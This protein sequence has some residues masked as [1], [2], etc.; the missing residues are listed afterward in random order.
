MS[1]QLSENKPILP[2]F[3]LTF[4]LTLPGYILLY[5]TANGSILTPDMT[6]VFIPVITLAPVSAALIL[7]ARNEGRA[8]VKKLL[9]RTFDY[10]RITRKSWIATTLLFPLAIFLVALAVAKLL[11]FTTNPAQAPLILFPIVFIGLFGGAWGENIAWM[12]YAFDTMENR[13]NALKA[14]IILGL[15]LT[16]WHIPIYMYATDDPVFLPSMILFPLTLRILAVWIFNNTGKSVFAATVFHTLFNV[17]Y[18]LLEAN[19]ATVTAVSVV[20]AIAVAYFWGPKT[21]A[22]F[23]GNSNQT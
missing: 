9:W 18:I 21:M 5:L 7:T 6:M 20:A 3:L 22:N 8:A 4:A 11:G 16:L 17:G 15:I 2:F 1:N 14:A 13:W 10:K 19:L 23:R 12:G